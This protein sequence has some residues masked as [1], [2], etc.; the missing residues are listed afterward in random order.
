[1]Q[2]AEEPRTRMQ[3][4]LR[5]YRPRWRPPPSNTLVL[6]LVIT[7]TPL[8]EAHWDDWERMVAQFMNTGREHVTTGA[9]GWGEREG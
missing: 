9:G 5:V 3:L 4:G 7:A 1:M 8:Q 6:V 2:R